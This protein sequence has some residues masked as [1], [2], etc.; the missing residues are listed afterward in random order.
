MQGLCSPPAPSCGSHFCSEH[1]GPYLYLAPHSSPGAAANQPLF[2]PRAYTPHPGNRRWLWGDFPKEVERPEGRRP[3]GKP[4]LPPPCPLLSLPQFPRFSEVPLG[5]TWRQA[6]SCLRDF[7]KGKE[8]HTPK[9][10]CTKGEIGQPLT[11]QYNSHYPWLS[12]GCP[13]PGD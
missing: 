2:C 1:T 10:L 8:A 4:F 7:R 9:C 3:P 5:P 11:I 12:V 13:T 6:Q